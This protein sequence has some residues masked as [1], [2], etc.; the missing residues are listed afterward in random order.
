MPRV[1][2]LSFYAPGCK[3][4]G[5][6]SRRIIP[7]YFCCE[8]TLSN[9]P[10]MGFRSDRTDNNMQNV[11]LFVPN[12][13]NQPPHYTKKTK[14]LPTYCSTL[15]YHNICTLSTSSPISYSNIV[16]VSSPGN[17]VDSNQWILYTRATTWSYH[18]T[19]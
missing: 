4:V 14:V 16:H 5:M 2:H 8:I 3:A 15:Y 6:D 7:V 10:Y 17:V 9:I 18:C 19:E 13:H 11:K 12:E 1:I